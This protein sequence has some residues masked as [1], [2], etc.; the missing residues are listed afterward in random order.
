MQGSW[1]TNSLGVVMILGAICVAAKAL[2][3]TDPE[4][5]INIEGTIAAIMAGIALIMARDNNVSSEEAGATKP[6]T[7]PEV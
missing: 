1:R 4:T 5:V 3:D 2:L 6:E 7:K